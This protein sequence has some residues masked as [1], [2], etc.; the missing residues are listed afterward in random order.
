MSAGDEP[1]KRGGRRTPKGLVKPAPSIFEVLR[2]KRVPATVDG[3][4]RE[5]PL[6]QVLQ[7]TVVHDAFA[8]KRKA[9][10]TALKWIRE[11][12]DARAAKD[13]VNVSGR[14][15]FEKGDPDNIDEALLILG[16]ATEEKGR[17]WVKGRRPLLLESWGVQL[18]LSRR[19]GAKLTESEA[20]MIERSTRDSRWLRWPRGMKR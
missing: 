18:A 5:L 17:I 8:G 10:R 12:E 11:R 6:E 20:D 16:I 13:P 9:V 4:Q 7:H 19:T 2:D 3:E 15:L 1:P 14:L